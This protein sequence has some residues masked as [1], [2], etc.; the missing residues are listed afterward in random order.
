MIPE[1]RSVFT[2]AML[3]YTCLG[4]I[5]LAIHMTTVVTLTRRSF[6]SIIEERDGWN[7]LHIFG[8]SEDFLQ[9]LPREIDDRVRIPN[10]CYRETPKRNGKVSK[11]K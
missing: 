3:T 5:L 10:R 8:L 6:F 1:V 11:R 9:C 2:F 4:L 7:K